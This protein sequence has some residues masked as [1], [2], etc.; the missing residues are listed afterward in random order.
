MLLSDEGVDAEVSLL[1]VWNSK[2]AQNS[3]LIEAL[4]KD[5]GSLI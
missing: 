1:S 4:D 3:G 2:S 5:F